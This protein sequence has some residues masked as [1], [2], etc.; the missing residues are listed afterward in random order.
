MG[1]INSSFLTDVSDYTKKKQIIKKKKNYTFYYLRFFYYVSQTFT[2]LFFNNIS[3]E[4]LEFWINICKK[5][6]NKCL[7]GQAG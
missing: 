3:P 2:A 6:V 5:I 1:L 4:K 7:M